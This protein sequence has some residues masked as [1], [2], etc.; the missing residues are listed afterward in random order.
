[1]NNRDIVNIR[2]L[3]FFSCFFLGLFFFPLFVNAQESN[4]AE[5][6]SES[7]TDTVQNERLNSLEI[8]LEE[9]GYSINDIE[10]TIEKLQ[11]S[12]ILQDQERLAISDKIDLAVIALNDLINYSIELLEKIDN[13]ELLA[14]E[15]R[16][17]VLN[18]FVS[19]KADIA[20][21]NEN[22]VSGNALISSLN[23]SFEKELK[24]ASASSIQEFN[25]TLLKTNTLLSYLFVLLLFLL[26]MVVVIG[27]GLLLHNMINRFVR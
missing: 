26:V 16:T 1:M 10:V 24:A 20:A 13:E 18:A 14:S 5:S 9:L 15:Y 2:I 12:E 8:R 22:T 3:F 17:K 4:E 7:G 27:L 21:L 25:H 19:N 23:D 11:E 6:L